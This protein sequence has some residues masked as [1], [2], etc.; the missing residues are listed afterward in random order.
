MGFW[1]KFKE[2]D[3][4]MSEPALIIRTEKRIEVPNMQFRGDDGMQGLI[5]ENKEL[6][7]QLKDK[8]LKAIDMDY[9]LLE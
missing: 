2:F 7:K 5:E 3:K 8:R 6:R 9:K 1:E 4:M